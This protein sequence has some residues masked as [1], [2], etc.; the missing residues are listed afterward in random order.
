MKKHLIL[1]AAALTT[2]LGACSNEE[3]VIINENAKVNFVIGGPVTRTSTDL[4]TGTSSFI[5]NTDKIGIY[6]TGLESDIKDATFTVGEEGALT[7]EG[8]TSYYF[9]TDGTKA[10]FYSHY[11]ASA[12][13]TETQATFSVSADQSTADSYN[14]SDFMTAKNTD[15]EAASTDIK[16]QFAHRATLI[17][18]NVNDLTSVTSVK[19]NGVQPDITW[20]YATD[21]VTT[22]GTATDVAMG[23]AKDQTAYYAVIPAQTITGNGTTALITIEADG[24][25]YTYKPA[26]N[27]AFNENKRKVFT[28]TTQGAAQGELV[29]LVTEMDTE[30]GEEE[31]D[32][33][34]TIEQEIKN[35]IT[36]PTTTTNVDIVTNRTQ[37][38]NESPWGFLDASEGASASIE[39]NIL[40]VKS[41]TTSTSWYNRTLYYYSNE[42]LEAGTYTL[43]FKAKT[44][45][46]KKNIQ[47]SLIGGSAISGSNTDFYQITDGDSNYTALVKTANTTEETFEFKINTAAYINTASPSTQAVTTDFTATNNSLTGFYVAFAFQAETFTI[48][49]LKLTKN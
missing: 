45:S 28:L 18:V 9:K 43:S 47:I 32:E 13:A 39:N 2:M 37:V 46:A 7:A 22:S 27:V 44:S 35:Y 38:T 1:A 29:S 11:P 17:K 25:T 6:S 40:T 36:L 15:V 20:T 24:K 49:D 33:N 21:V 14:N 48:S 4:S 8:G 23:V 26:A 3:E 19:I 16:L 42:T 31:G 41:A 34:A 12:T 10:N 30:W 5:A